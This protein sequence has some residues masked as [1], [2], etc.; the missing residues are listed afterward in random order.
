VNNPLPVLT[1][2]SPNTGTAGSAINITATGY[3]FLTVSQL[4]LNGTPLTTTYVSST[5]LT[6][7]I[8]ASAF[9]AAD[10]ASVTVI[11]PSPGGGISNGQNFLAFSGSTRLKII[12]TAANN[13]VWDSVHSSLYATLPGTSGSVVAI[14]PVTASM[15][16]PQPAGNGPNMLDISSDAAHL[17]VGDDGTGTVQRFS[18]P[19]LA[20]E[21]SITLPLASGVAQDALALKAA[22]ASPNNVAVLLGSASTPYMA[23][24]VLVYTDTTPQTWV[25][26]S[27]GIALVGLAWG[28]DASTLYA[29][30][31]EY[32]TFGLT[33]LHMSGSNVTS[34]GYPYVFEI[35][36][37][38][39]AQRIHF[40]ATSG[41]VYSDYGRV[42]N[43]ATG[44]LAGT[45]NLDPLY[46][47]TNFST[48]SVVDAAQ[49]VVFFLG[50]TIAQWFAH[51]GYTIVA[52]DKATYRPLRVLDLPQVAGT[53]T[54]FVSWGRAGLA[55][56]TVSSGYSG[57][58]SGIYLLDGSFVN[59]SALAD[60][61]DGTGV[62][63]L[64]QLS[65]ISPQSATAGA[66]SKPLTITGANFQPGDIVYWGGSALS[67]TYVNPGELQ[68]TIPASY[69]VTAASVYIS[70]GD[71]VIPYAA[72]N[73]LAFT[74]NSAAAATQVTAMNLAA[75]DLAWDPNS[76]LLYVPVWSADAQYPNSVVAVDPV[77]GAV[78]KSVYAG[79][80][81]ALVRTT[82]DG[83]YLYAG[84]LADNAA[85]QMPLPALNSLL[86]WSLGASNLFGPLAALD[87]QPA[88]GA[89]QTTVIATA[90]SV[91]E[92]NSI[93]PY[94]ITAA[95]NLT[96]FDNSVARPTT[97][98]TAPPNL[99]GTLQWGANSSTLYAADNEDTSFM[100]YQ[101]AATSSGLNVQQYCLYCAEN[102][103]LAADPSEAAYNFFA[104]LHF[105]IGTGYLYD[106]NGV[107][108]DPSTGRQVNV[109]PSYGLVVPDSSLNRVFIL[110]QTEYYSG[111]TQSYTIDSYN[112]TTFAAVGS[113]TLNNVVG[114][115]MAL[116]RWGAS[117]LALVTFN[118]PV[119]GT[120]YPPGMLYIIS[121]TS[122]VSSLAAGAP[123]SDA[124]VAP[125]RRTWQR[126][127]F[128]R[129]LKTPLK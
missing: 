69:M 47:Q 44:D 29:S 45:F 82:A 104:N 4:A 62:D 63:A 42:V 90:V 36:A 98:A 83:R 114:M 73:Q 24:G 119:D 94:Y 87:I 126:P 99:F 108:V 49:G 86:S 41:L 78:T 103:V 37:T 112:Q 110:G 77:T 117:G 100:L 48:L 105:D 80:D 70:V 20:P 46:T 7:Q 124:V 129:A 123:G 59:G 107:V 5:Q 10:T 23:D 61:T 58:T 71:G 76:A 56:N 15:G 109:F 57:S 118:N 3:N 31:G 84:F 64:P 26:S 9:T 65:A 17:W 28:P 122:F 14:N 21:L 81:P 60:F 6:A 54:S 55:F 88:P 43:A 38:A 8:P 102:S 52:F 79:S 75:F 50:Q 97:I 93:H 19:G 74:I 18:V 68:A 106:D 12:S 116:V 121:D 2:I 66:A 39:N 51:L 120:Q 40:D 95:G 89:S 30:Q 13:I 32:G 22:P 125:V 67:T 35:G 111:G 25:N 85:A 16:T 128:G 27:S 72:M 53:P 92:N 113:F 11:N 33:E 1:T 115:P 101:L 127:W 91:L 34:A 96:L